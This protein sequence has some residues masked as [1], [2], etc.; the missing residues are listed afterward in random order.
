MDT[1]QYGIVIL[2]WP[3][4]FYKNGTMDSRVV[5]TTTSTSS[6]FGL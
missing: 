5:S 3:I 4:A 2:K 6:Y 1:S